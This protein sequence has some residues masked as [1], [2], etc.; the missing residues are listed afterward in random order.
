MV[1]SSILLLCVKAAFVDSGFRNEELNFLPIFR[2]NF[3]T[4]FRCF[5]LSSNRASL[6]SHSI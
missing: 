6:S 5:I 3:K 4:R 1:T 2:A